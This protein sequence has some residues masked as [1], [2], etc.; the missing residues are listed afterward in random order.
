MGI[1]AWGRCHLIA[2]KK[3]TCTTSLT[4]ESEF[5]ALTT[6][7][8]ED[9][10]LINLILE[11]PLWSKP[12]KPISI[13]CGS[14]TTL[15]KAYSQMYNGKSRHL[16]VRHNMIRELIINGVISLVLARSQKN[17]A[18]HLMKGLARDLVSKSVKG[19]GLK[20]NISVKVKTPNSILRKIRS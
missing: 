3:Q 12:I 13:R 15:V 4:M 11:I 5:I 9:E 10:W 14:A 1:L 7:G 8:N 19:M 6:A 16:G 20:S 2:S 18:D 17:L